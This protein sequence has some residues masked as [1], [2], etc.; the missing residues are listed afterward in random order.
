MIIIRNGL[1]CRLASGV[2]R[3]RA[4]NS[5]GSLGTRGSGG[6]GGAPEL[7]ADWSLR[8]TELKSHSV[9]WLVGELQFNVTLLP[10]VVTMLVGWA[11]GVVRNDVIEIE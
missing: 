2:S 8:W 5:I 3:P 4:Y 1:P 11:V 9:D 7:N 10:N 6:T